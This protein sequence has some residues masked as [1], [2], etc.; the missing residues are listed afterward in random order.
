MTW[1]IENEAFAN[2]DI[3]LPVL[4]SLGKDYIL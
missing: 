4:K 2:G 1:I 3:L